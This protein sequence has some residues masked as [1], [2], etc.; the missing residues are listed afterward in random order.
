MFAISI[1]SPHG[2]NIASGKK[3]LEIRSW[4]PE[5]LPVR[6]LLIVENSEFLSIDN[7]IDPNGKAVAIVDIEEIH[8]WQPSEVAEA[9]SSGWKPGYWAWTLSNVRPISTEQV[10]PAK[11]KLYAVELSHAEV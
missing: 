7:P 1:V 9:C 5:S 8:E 11:R 10:V 2:T 3:T 6:D 4:R